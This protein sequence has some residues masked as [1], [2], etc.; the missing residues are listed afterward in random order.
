MRALTG[1]D[2]EAPV[3]AAGEI[4]WPSLSGRSHRWEPHRREPL[5]RADVARDPAAKLSYVAC[6]GRYSS[7]KM[8]LRFPYESLP[9]LEAMI[10]LDTDPSVVAFHSQPETFRWRDA[11]QHRR[12]TPDFVLMFADGRRQYREVKTE[13]GLRSDPTLKGKLPR[14]LVECA[15]RD[16][17]FAFWT[18]AQIRIEPRLSNAKRLRSGFGHLDAPA[19]ARMRDAV[20]R[21]GLPSTIGELVKAAG[22]GLDTEAAVLGLAGLGYL[23]IDV[24]A[25]LGPDASVTLGRRR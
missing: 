15:S 25:G 20:R 14:I 3:V 23:S 9:E 5:P 17:D 21:V 1:P 24:F 2:G 16:A 8:D 10:L 22:G 6:A 19:I 18:V 13:Q 12:Y 4:L 11:G 7:I